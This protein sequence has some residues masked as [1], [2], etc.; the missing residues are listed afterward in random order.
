MNRILDCYIMLNYITRMF[1]ESSIDL[2]A[3]WVLRKTWNLHTLTMIDQLTGFL[4]L[5]P[6]VDETEE[7]LTTAFICTIVHIYGASITVL[8]DN[9]T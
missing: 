9:G 2:V 3:K 1:D 8:S 4:T 6:T 7:Y 5:V